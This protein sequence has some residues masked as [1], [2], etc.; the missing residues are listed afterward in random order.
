MSPIACVPQLASRVA[1]KT[2]RIDVLDRFLFL[3]AVWLAC[4]MGVSLRLIGPFFLVV[5]IGFCVF[6]ALLRQTAPPKLLACYFAFCILVA[7]LSAYRL[8]PTSWQVHFEPD[9]IVR[10]MIPMVGFFAVAWA[11]KA[12]FARRLAAADPF[13]AAPVFLLLSLVVA[14]AVMFQQGRQYQGQSVEDSILALY[15]ALINNVTIAMLFLTRSIFW[16][17]G[18]RRYGALG[19]ILAIAVTTHFI[20][21]RVLTAALLII[22]VS[23]HDRVV[24]VFI[25]VA[26]AAAYAIGLNYIPEIM[27]SAP[28]SGLRLAFMYDAIKSVIDTNGLG[29]GYG[30]E[31]VRWRYSFPGMPV[32]TFLPNA[33]TMT[34]ERLLSALSTGVENSFMQAMLRSGVVGFSL[35]LSA[36]IVAIPSARLPRPVRNHATTIFI[37]MVINCFVNSSLES[38]LAVVGEGFCYGYLVALKQTASARAGR[39]PRR[40]PRFA[41]LM[42]A[43]G[44][45]F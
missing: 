17:E 14:P 9:A 42:D 30:T 13:Y 31:S 28:N 19:F 33:N 2:S 6:Y 25:I 22:F 12:Y 11:A 36:Y 4:G 37:M 39:A 21:F 7:F 3:P 35:L 41:G 5:P 43:R 15:G 8:M 44:A 45:P 16:Q 1:N 18:T 20:Q 34:H 26:L 29:I 40:K 10:Q 32:F 27:L 38:P 24:A 23:R